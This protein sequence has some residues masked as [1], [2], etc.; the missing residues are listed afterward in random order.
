MSNDRTCYGSRC[1]HICRREREG[2]GEMEYGLVEEMEV[3]EDGATKRWAV[4]GK[5]LHL[6]RGDIPRKKRKLAGNK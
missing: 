2:R 6:M 1:F 4:S 5:R 3:Y